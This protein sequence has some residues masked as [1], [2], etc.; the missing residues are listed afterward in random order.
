MIGRCSLFV[1]D[2]LDQF[3]AGHVRQEQI[4]HD[5]IEPVLL[6]TC[7]SAVRASA[8]QSDE[9]SRFRS[10]HECHCAGFRRLRSPA[11]FFAARIPLISCALRRSDSIS[12]VDRLRQKS[13]RALFERVLR[14]VVSRDDKD[15]N[16]TR[17]QDRI[18][19]GLSICQPSTSGRL[20][21]SVIADG[22]NLAHQAP[23]RLSPAA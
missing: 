2:L 10:T 3:E 6:A 22:A 18:S 23:E 20:R 15:R 8:H 4:E 19:A 17:R 7:A 14:L 9:R 11:S 12:T 1:P 21:S 16:V 5:A 13:E